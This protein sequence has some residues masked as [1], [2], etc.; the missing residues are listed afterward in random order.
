MDVKDPQHLTLMRL[1]GK[2]AQRAALDPD[3]PRG[4]LQYAAICSSLAE[5]MRMDEVA[6]VE[7]IAEEIARWGSRGKNG[8]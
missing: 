5:S 1:V 6:N 7:N 4:W 8:S 3:G 2:F